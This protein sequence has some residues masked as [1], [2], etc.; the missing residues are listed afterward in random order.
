MIMGEREQKSG[1]GESQTL[2]RVL[3]TGR[4]QRMARRRKKRQGEGAEG[5]RARQKI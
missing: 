5:G 3:E 4:K 1:E 2:G